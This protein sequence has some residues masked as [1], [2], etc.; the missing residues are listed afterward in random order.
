VPASRLILLFL[1]ASACRAPFP[2]APAPDELGA[3][4]EEV[5]YRNGIPSLAAAAIDSQGVLAISAVGF[6]KRGDPTLVTAQDRFHLGSDTKAMT[7]TLIAMYVEEGRLRWETKLEEAFPELAQ[8]MDRGYRAVTVSDLLHHTAGL[9]HDFRPVLPGWRGALRRPVTEQRRWFVG[10]ITALPPAIPPGTK[11]VYSNA[12]YMIAGAVLEKLSGQSW[13]ELIRARLFAPL[14]MRSC[15]FGAPATA[16]KVD[17]PYPH[18]GPDFEPVP[19]GPRADNPPGL[20]P[21]GTVHCNLED[22]GKFVRDHLRGAR[23]AGKLLKTASYERL[24]A[25]GLGGYAMGWGVAAR[26]WAR[27]KTLSHSGSNLMNFA[28][29]WIAPEIDR[30]FL[31]ATNAGRRPAP[32]AVDQ[33]IGVLVRRYAR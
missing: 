21:A 10:A 26:P 28:T 33:A 3:A 5:R 6:R 31:A 27:G 15:G 24:H 9:P 23:G 20:G 18:R 13:E 32:K 4:L 11:Y 2:H 25:A 7:A 8:R 30:A 12:G 29:V 16:G 17:E 1:A 14:E 19:P 22:W